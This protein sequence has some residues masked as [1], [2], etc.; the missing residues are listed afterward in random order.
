MEWNE[1]IIK[2]G[3]EME[4]FFFNN[5]IV[6]GMGFEWCVHWEQQ[7]VSVERQTFGGKGMELNC[8]VWMF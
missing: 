1:C 5:L 2:E 7:E 6:G 3:K 4:P 8:L